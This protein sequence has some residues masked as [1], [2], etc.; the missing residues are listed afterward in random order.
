MANVFN[1]YFT[2]AVKNIQI[3][4]FNTEPVPQEII[5]NIDSIIIKYKNHP[6]I[7]KIKCNTKFKSKFKFSIVL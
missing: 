4:Q 1:D 6:S 3:K 7:R 2:T 5:D